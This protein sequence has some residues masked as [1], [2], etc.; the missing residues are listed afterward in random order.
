MAPGEH[1]ITFELGG[2]KVASRR[3]GVDSGKVS[4]LSVRLESLGR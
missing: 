4:T 3:I 1:T 2:Y